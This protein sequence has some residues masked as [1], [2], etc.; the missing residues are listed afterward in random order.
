MRSVLFLGMWVSSV[1]C[2]AQGPN[3][4]QASGSSVASS[5]S[6][7]LNQ[8]ETATQPTLFSSVATKIGSVPP[9]FIASE[10]V[11]VP[12]QPSPTI[13]R[14][15]ERRSPWPRIKREWILLTALQHG[16]ATF[17]AWSTRQS[18][19]SGNGYERN[20]L[21]RPFAHSAAIY[22]AIQLAPLGTDWISWRMARSSKPLVRKMWWLPQTI[23]TTGFIWSGIRNLH[24][25]NMK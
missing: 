24:V 8:S 11:I 17:D 18:L 15:S 25:T 9:S 6:S 23:A 13:V 16:S 7:N 14:N 22:P 5:G 3:Q 20:P 4:I 12:L 21:M 10:A 19:A 1:L 2:L